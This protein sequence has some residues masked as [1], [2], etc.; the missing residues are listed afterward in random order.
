MAMSIYKHSKLVKFQ[1]ALFERVK[2]KK[3]AL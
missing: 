3:S 1:V 2:G